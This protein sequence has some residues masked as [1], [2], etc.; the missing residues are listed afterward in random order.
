[1]IKSISRLVEQLE[2]LKNVQKRA[3]EGF[4]TVIEDI[5]DDGVDWHITEKPRRLRRI[6][7]VKDCDVR[8]AFVVSVIDYS[9]VIGHHPK[10]MIDGEKIIVDVFTAGI[11]DIMAADREMAKKID[12]IMIDSLSSKRSDV[13]FERYSL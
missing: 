4:I 12:E 2:P 13:S 10:I 11:D 7:V 8:S 1:M 3:R 5:P 9:S 6:F